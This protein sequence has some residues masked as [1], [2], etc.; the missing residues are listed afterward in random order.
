MGTIETYAR[1]ITIFRYRRLSGG[2]ARNPH[3]NPK[4]IEQELKPLE[5]NYIYCSTYRELNDP[6]EGIFNAS[7]RVQSRKDYDETVQLIRDQKLGLGIASFSETWDNELMWAHYG[8]DFAGICI[9]YSVTKLLGG[10][11]CDCALARVAYGDRP[12]YLGLGALRKDHRSRAILSTKNLKWSYEREWRLFAASSGPAHYTNDAVN[13]V[14]LGARMSEA[15]RL[16]V[17][18]RLERLGLKIR[19]TT[20]DGYSITLVD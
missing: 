12:Y 5:Q 13:C 11:P 15:D 2:R 3:A 9:G 14:Y 16:L 20:V 7:R 19:R 4:L 17:Q 10:L 18:T 1:P 8:G 6:M